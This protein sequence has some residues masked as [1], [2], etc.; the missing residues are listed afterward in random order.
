MGKQFIVM[1]A[2]LPNQKAWAFRWLFSVVFSKF[3]PKL[4]LRRVN[5]IIF[6]GDSQEYNQIDAGIK[7]VMPNAR[8]V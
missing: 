3:F 8:R 2:L 4:L 6:D 7:K 1:R 5:I